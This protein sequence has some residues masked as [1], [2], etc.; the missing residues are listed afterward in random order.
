MGFMELKFFKAKKMLENKKKLRNLKEME[1]F[2]DCDLTRTKL[3]AYKL[4]R[5]R[6]IAKRNK[7]SAVLD[8]F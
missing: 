4:L 7:G 2:I 5:E 1:V 6:A 8:K 3:E